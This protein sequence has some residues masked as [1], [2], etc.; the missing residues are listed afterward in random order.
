MRSIEVYI[1]ALKE[2]I[3]LP[4]AY[5]CED[6]ASFN[7]AKCVECDGGKCALLGPRADEF[8]GSAGSKFFMVTDDHRALLDS[9]YFFI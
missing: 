1:D 9:K 2:A 4:K 3:P 6:F 8:L 5:Q 7:Q